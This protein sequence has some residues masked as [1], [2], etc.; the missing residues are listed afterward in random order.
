MK[1]HRP[2]EQE[3]RSR[4]EQIFVKNGCVPEH[5]VDNWL[6]AEYELMQSPV[7]KIAEL[8]PVT[9]KRGKAVTSSLV[10]LIHAALLLEANG[11]TQYLRR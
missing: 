11:L 3:I 9:V 4:A 6:Q 10:C 7:H 1:L 8:A 2:T 5:D